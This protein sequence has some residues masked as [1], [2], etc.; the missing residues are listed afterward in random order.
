[1]K[2]HWALFIFLLSFNTY[3]EQVDQELKAILLKTI[4]ESSSFEDRFEAEVWL[5]QKSS[6]LEKFVKDPEERLFL[7]KEIH[8]AA[9]RAELPPEFV[10]ALIEVESHFDQFAISTVGAQGLMQVM[11]FWKKEIGRPQDNLTDVKTNLRYGCTI[12]KYY[13]DRADNHWAEALSRY[14]GSYGKLWYPRRVMNAWDKHW[15]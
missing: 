7:L 2:A 8:K 11:P 15:R 6:V 13:L 1:M 9:T 10:L 4:A 12:L 3:A 5:L 14:N